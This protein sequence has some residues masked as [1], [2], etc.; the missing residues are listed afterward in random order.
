MLKSDLKF[1]PTIHCHYNQG[2]VNKTI[3][4]ATWNLHYGI[5]L[6]EIL[7]SIR[8]NKNFSDIDFLMLQ[9]ASLHNGIED[10]STISAATSAEGYG[11]CVWR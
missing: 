9:E 4:I 8:T 2:S 7:T 6:N 10:A 3:N 5:E 1:D 11:S